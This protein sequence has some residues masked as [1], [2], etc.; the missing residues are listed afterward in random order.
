[1]IQMPAN[2]I[3]KLLVLPLSSTD[4]TVNHD[5]IAWLDAFVTD[6]LVRGP[7][8][9]RRAPQLSHAQLPFAGTER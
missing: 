8:A 3:A 5:E 1:M 4:A 9:I 2:T 7:I 6:V